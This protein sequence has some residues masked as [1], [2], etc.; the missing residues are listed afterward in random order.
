ML[1]GSGGEENGG[2]EERGV[3]PRRHTMV[4]DE[5]MSKTETTTLRIQRC[6][7]VGELDDEFAVIGL[8][9]AF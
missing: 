7:I 5:Q 8:Y 3:E 1:A 6:W 9:I 2:E 4:N